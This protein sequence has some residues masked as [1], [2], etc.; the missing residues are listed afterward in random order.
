MVIPKFI[1][2][3]DAAGHSETVAVREIEKIVRDP[4][5]DEPVLCFNSDFREP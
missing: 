3:T 4:D 1:S 5:E 2:V